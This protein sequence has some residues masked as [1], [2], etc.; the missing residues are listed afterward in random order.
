MWGAIC[1]ISTIRARPS[2]KFFWAWDP[3]RLSAPCS[4][5]SSEQGWEPALSSRRLR[6]AFVG[7][8]VLPLRRVGPRH[9]GH[10][11]LGLAQIAHLVRNPRLDEDEVARFIVDA[12]RT[13]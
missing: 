9:H 1:S 12:Q 10:H 5:I 7:D 2:R 13:V 3:W 4:P 11:R 6:P 8:D